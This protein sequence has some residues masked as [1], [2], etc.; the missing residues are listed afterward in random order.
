M[1]LKVEESFRA[2]V[3]VWDIPCIARVMVWISYPG[4]GSKVSQQAGWNDFLP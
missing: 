2:H 3:L 4:G 1:I